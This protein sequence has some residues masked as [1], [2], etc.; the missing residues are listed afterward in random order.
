MLNIRIYLQNT[1]NLFTEIFVTYPL[2]FITIRPGELMNIFFRKD[3]RILIAQHLQVLMEFLQFFFTIPT[4]SFLCRFIFQWFFVNLY[5]KWYFSNYI[6]TFSSIVTQQHGFVKGRSA[7]SSYH[8]GSTVLVDDW[9]YFYWPWK[10]VWQS[11]PCST[12]RLNS[13]FGYS[14][15]STILAKNL[16]AKSVSQC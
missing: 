11:R 1:F 6:Q 5:R 10:G 9:S 4:A 2:Q 8:K 13:S 16:S 15:N 14:W 12:N 7:A 3:W